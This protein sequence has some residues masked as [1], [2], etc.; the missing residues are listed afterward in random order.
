MS[1]IF[2][3]KQ[4]PPTPPT[5]TDEDSS[6]STDNDEIKKKKGNRAMKKQKYPKAVKYYSKAIKIDP[7]NAT[8]RL[9]RAIANAALELWKDAEADAASAVDLGD[10]PSSK[11]YWQL[12]RAMLR[13]GRCTEAKETVTAGLKEYPT[14]RALQ[15]LRQEIERAIKQ[16]EETRRKAAEAEARRPEATCGPSEIYP[17]LDRARSA[18]D[19]GNTD[20]ALRLAADARAAAD[21]AAA[22]GADTRRQVA[23]LS[24]LKGKALLRHRRWDEAAEAFSEVVRVE[25][26]VYSMQN[27][28]E[29]E[30]LSNAY[31]NLGIAYKSAG[32]MS[33]AVEAMQT[34]YNKASNGN[35]QTATIQAAQILENIAQ[36]MRAQQRYEEAKQF[37]SRSIE[38]TA[39]LRRPDH[40]SLAL[41]RVGLARCLRDEGKLSEAI[42]CYSAALKIWMSKEPE[43]CLEETPELPDKARLVQVQVQTKKELAQLLAIV[44]EVRKKAGQQGLASEAAGGAE[45]ASL[46][47][48]AAG[49]EKEDTEV[50][51]DATGDGA[52]AAAAGDAVTPGAPAP[53]LRETNIG[54]DGGQ[55]SPRPSC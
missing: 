37:Y 22:T 24:S 43:V 8:Y 7:R 16:R 41:S 39:R 21:A 31:N 34:A 44:E 6:G 4:T 38:I 48:G 14:E 26:E 23:S 45:P 12:A 40:A 36:C 11:S 46:E 50:V 33:K 47:S 5:T 51:E 17:L 35:D 1:H 42:D 52:E 53:D 2:G 10:P 18:Y 9:N 20:E 15:Q 13:R 30:A 25:E 32:Q 49:V 54:S 3:C 19:M 27:L 55:E 28:D 29:R